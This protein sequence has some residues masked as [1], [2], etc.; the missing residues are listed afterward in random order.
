MAAVPCSVPKRVRIDQDNND[1]DS[2]S[3]SDHEP[4]LSGQ[5]GEPMN[6]AAQMTQRVTAPSIPPK[7]YPQ[8]MIVFASFGI[9]GMTLFEIIFGVFSDLNNG[10]ENE[11][12]IVN[13]CM[14]HYRQYV[15]HLLLHLQ[16]YLLLMKRVMYDMEIML[17]NVYL[18]LVHVKI[19]LIMK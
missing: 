9:I 1:G 13:Y 11:I 6:S 14:V 16:Q 5:D 8:I 15:Q 4:S 7:H 18:V 3:A 17:L 12:I 19:I 10:F 2:D